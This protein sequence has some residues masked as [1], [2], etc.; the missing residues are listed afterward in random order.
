MSRALGRPEVLSAA[1]RKRLQEAVRTTGYVP[2]LAAG[3][4]AS[5]RSRLVAIFLPTI[6]NS[7]FAD[8]VPAL[9]DR[10]ASNLLGENL[11]DILPG[12]GENCAGPAPRWDAA[13]WRPRPSMLSTWRYGASRRAAPACRRYACSARFGAL[14]QHLWRFSAYATRSV[15]EE[16]R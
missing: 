16:H 1:T 9:T 6:A 15:A 7:I 11:S 13:A 2:N 5:S 10:L 14:L 4:L 12:C 8:T 3:A